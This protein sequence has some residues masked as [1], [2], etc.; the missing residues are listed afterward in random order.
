MEMMISLLAIA[1]KRKMV[2]EDDEDDMKSRSA[3]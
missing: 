2:G 3:A 1:G